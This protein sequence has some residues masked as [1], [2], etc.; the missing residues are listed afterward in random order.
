MKKIIFLLL[1]FLP[2]KSIFAIDMFGVYPSH[3]FTGMK[4]ANLQLMMHGENIAGY[5]KVTINHPG[6]KVLKVNK[7]GNKNYIFVDL[8]I[9]PTSKPENFKIVLTR[10]K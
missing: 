2:G 7:V 5:T 8:S 6:V 4:N 9:A 1:I 3:W 10:L